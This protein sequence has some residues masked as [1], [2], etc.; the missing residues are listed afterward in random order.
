MGLIVGSLGT[1]L[2]LGIV[3]E[4]PLDAGSGL[5]SL[6]NDSNQDV[7][8]VGQ[9]GEP[10]TAADTEPGLPFKFEFGELLLEEEYVLSPPQRP[11]PPEPSEPKDETAASS[12]STT[13][14]PAATTASATA[15]ARD[16]G[17]SAYVIQVGS[18][19][20]FEDADR[21][22]ATLALSGL[23]TF[24][25]K[26]TVEGRGEFY[27][28]RVGPFHQYDSAEQTTNQLI[29]LEY[30]PLIFRIKASG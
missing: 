7:A 10:Q 4:S 5:G 11:E 1:V 26:V 21:I 23:E 28:V 27:R 6:L 24:I 19:R 18:F 17:K 12:S 9:S 25:Q 14:Q 3:D 16:D 22:K 20:K 30:Q 13:A 2:T 8:G 15:P 29:Q